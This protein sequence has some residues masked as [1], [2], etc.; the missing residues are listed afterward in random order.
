MTKPARGR[1]PRSPAVA[2]MLKQ[3]A[4]L[5][6]TMPDEQLPMKFHP[7]VERLVGDL[8]GLK[9]P[10]CW[11]QFFEFAPGMSVRLTMLQPEGV[12]FIT[13]K[14]KEVNLNKQPNLLVQHDQI[15][16]RDQRRFFYR[17]QI[18]QEAAIKA[19]HFPEGERLKNC[20]VRLSDISAGG[21]GF[22]AGLFL[23]PGT[24]VIMENLLPP[25]LDEPSS[26]EE[27]QLHVVWCHKNRRQDYR[28]GA[29]FDYPNP[30]AQDDMVKMINQVQRIK[31]NKYSQV[32]DSH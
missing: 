2:N 20:P 32:R 24:M 11:W 21:L 15:I 28:V 3:E 29:C 26:R 16:K 22:T 1:R 17:V 30:K 25:L 19:L 31:L 12:F 18:D 8:L 27:H 10:A 14:V 7:R 13:G 23:P 9:L 4:Y 6:L 5:I